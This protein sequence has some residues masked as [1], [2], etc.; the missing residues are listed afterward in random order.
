LPQHY[1]PKC[2]QEVEW[3]FEGRS[4]PLVH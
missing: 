4:V 2:L 3:L 1:K